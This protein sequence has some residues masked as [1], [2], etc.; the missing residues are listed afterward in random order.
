ML[1]LFEKLAVFISRCLTVLFMAYLAARDNTKWPPKYQ[2]VPLVTITIHWRVILCFVGS[3]FPQRPLPDLV[4]HKI[5]LLFIE[6]SSQGEN[7]EK[8]L[9]CHIRT[10]VQGGP[11]RKE[12]FVS[13]AIETLFVVF[14]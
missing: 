3:G 12:T 8:G 1:I 2:K 4:S 14:T 5:A 10:N 9:S 6:F 13:F 11:N 7:M